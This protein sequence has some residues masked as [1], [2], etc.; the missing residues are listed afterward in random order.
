[1]EEIIL[2]SGKSISGF[3]PRERGWI[4]LEKPEK[5]NIPLGTDDSKIYIYRDGLWVFIVIGWMK[6]CSKSGEPMV[7][8]GERKEKRKPSQKDIFDYPNYFS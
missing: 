7:E 3:D 1:M 5:E 6:V 8:G 2:K 4:F